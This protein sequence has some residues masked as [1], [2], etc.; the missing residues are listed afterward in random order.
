[1]IT[2]LLFAHLQEQ[3]GEREL[4]LAVPAMTVAEFKSMME[5]EYGLSD[6]GT[7]MIAVNEEFANDHDMINDGDTV[8]CIPPVS[9]G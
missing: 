6:A 2:V 9:G 4:K 3:I 8:A 5:A 7:I 1:M